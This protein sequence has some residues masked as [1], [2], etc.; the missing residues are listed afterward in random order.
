MFDVQ[1]EFSNSDKWELFW[2]QEYTATPVTEAL[3]R[4]YPIGTVSPGLL[5]EKQIIAIHCFSNTANLNWRYGAN[6][7]IKISTGLTVN[8]GIPQTVVKTG[9]IYLD[10]IEIIQIPPWSSTYSIEINIPYWH[11][12][13]GL[14]IWEYIGSNVNSVEESLDRIILATNA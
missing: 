9:K 10:Q 7:K 4:F 6:Y 1:F 5:I 11:R 12:H 8:G 2:N 13:F 3:E 14:T